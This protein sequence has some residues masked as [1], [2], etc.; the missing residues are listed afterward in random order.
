MANTA[1]AR[2]RAR[3]NLKRRAHNRSLRSKLRTAIKAVRLAVASGNK[4]EAQ[5]VFVQTQS[6]IDKMVGK[7]I[8]HKNTAARYKS[9]LSAKIKAL[10]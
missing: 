6:V 3:Q 5:T 1:Q 4:A 7:G 2:K 9:R 8:I 10:A